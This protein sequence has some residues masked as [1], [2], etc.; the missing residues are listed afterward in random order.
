MIY[1]VS[2][3]G[4]VSLLRDKAEATGLVTFYFKHELR[5]IE[6]NKQRCEVE[7]SVTG[8]TIPHEF[9]YLIGAD[10]GGSQVRECMKLLDETEVS[11]ELLDHSYKE[12]TVPAGSNGD[13]QLFKEALH[14]W[15]RGE[16]MMIG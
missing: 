14:I 9:E 5:S 2:R 11:S 7:N 15:P 8:A 13:F 4:L 3:A 6:F 10:G 16:Y 12:L 1:S